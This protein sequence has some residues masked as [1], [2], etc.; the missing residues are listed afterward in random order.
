MNED[1]LRF[2]KELHSDLVSLVECIEEVEA[3][4]GQSYD[5]VKTRRLLGLLHQFIQKEQSGAVCS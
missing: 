3:D 2:L 4:G 5:T 1:L